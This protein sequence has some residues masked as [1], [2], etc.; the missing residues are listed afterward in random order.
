MLPPPRPSML[1]PSLDQPFAD[2]HTIATSLAIR[3]EWIHKGHPLDGP[4]C[5]WYDNKKI[6]IR[7]YFFATIHDNNIY[8]M[9]VGKSHHTRLCKKHYVVVSAKT[10][11]CFSTYQCEYSDTIAMPTTR[12]GL[13]WLKNMKN[14]AVCPCFDSPSIQFGVCKLC[15]TPA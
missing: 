1:P 13:E 10:V 9:D 14:H 11:M 6:S 15:E 12:D 5:T 8:V 2:I 4:E 7:S 3:V